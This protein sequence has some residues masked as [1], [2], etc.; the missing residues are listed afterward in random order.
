MKA[1]TRQRL[2]IVL[3][4]ALAIAAA[5][6]YFI[7][8]GRGE[9][10]T[11]RVRGF[12]ISSRSM[13]GDDYVVPKKFYAYDL[14]SARALVGQT[15]WVKQGYGNFIYPVRGRAI[16]FSKGELTLRPIEKLIVAD[17]LQ[18]RRSSQGQLFAVFDHDGRS[19]ATLIGAIEGGD[20][21]LIAN[22]IFFLQ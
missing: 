17:V 4:A 6:L 7:H 5:R 16:D 3:V 13:T 15:V 20:L 14:K 10:G 8:R 18:Q 12:E 22:D 21:R 11:T 19:Y 1:A 2:Q 9:A